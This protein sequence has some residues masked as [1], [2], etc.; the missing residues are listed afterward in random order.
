MSTPPSSTNDIPPAEQPNTNAPPAFSSDPLGPGE[1]DPL[2]SNSVSIGFSSARDTASFAKYRERSDDNDSDGEQK[3]ENFNLKKSAEEDDAS[4]EKASSS[5]DNEVESLT[6][7]FGLQSLNYTMDKAK[8]SYLYH[9][10]KSQQCY[11]AILSEGFLL[12][13]ADDA[14]YDGA[15][16]R[17]D[18]PKGVFFV[19]TMYRGDLPTLTL[20]PRPPPKSVL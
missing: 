18:A 16:A 14:N 19:S 5:Q 10:T 20:Y 7:K 15:L 11:E 4:E 2:V 3:D 12:Y 6:V 8:V 17:P 9:V 13:N 1:I